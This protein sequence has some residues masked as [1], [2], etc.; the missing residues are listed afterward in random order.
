MHSSDRMVESAAAAEVAVK[1]YILGRMADVKVIDEEELVAR[2]RMR[3]RFEGKED[4]EEAK[5]RCR[6][7]DRV[8]TC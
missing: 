4:S 3:N 7:A 1:G 6:A 8:G 2:R 5:E